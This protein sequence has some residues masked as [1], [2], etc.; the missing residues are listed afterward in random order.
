[1]Y[2]THTENKVAPD[3]LTPR[4]LGEG[5][6]MRSDAEDGIGCDI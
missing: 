5:Q 6:V 4:N 1:M 3:H 2:E